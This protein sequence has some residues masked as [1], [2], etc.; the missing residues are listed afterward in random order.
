MQISAAIV[1]E[2]REKT[3]AG[4]M[5]CKKALVDAEGD[6]SKAVDLLRARGIAKAEKKAG[7]SAKEGIICSYVHPL[8]QKLGVMVE[9]NCE[10]D[11]VAKTDEFVRFAQDIAMQIAAMN[12]LA[13][14]REDIPAAIIEHEKAVYHDQVINEGKPAHIAERI[15]EGKLEKYYK[16]NV[17]LEQEFFKDTDKSVETYLKETIGSL[18]ENISIARF[19]RFMVGEAS[20]ETTEA[21]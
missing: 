4:M 17:L 19:A 2:L 12:P 20:E 8:G 5:D 21:S 6:I 15:V 9:V 16:E 3:G 13:V 14:R 11:F 18:G 10:T 7:R 1:K